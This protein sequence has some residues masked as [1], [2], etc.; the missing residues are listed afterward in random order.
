MYRTAPE[1]F[2]NG[3]YTSKSDVW[4][5]GVV[6]WEIFEKGAKPYGWMSTN[7]VVE[8]VQKGT[9]LKKPSNCSDEVFEIMTQCWNQ[10]DKLFMYM[11][12]TLL[13]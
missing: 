11:K 6:M 2:V 5:F 7:E 12:V 1:V 13:L 4:S 3:Q 8:Q 9:R 10:V